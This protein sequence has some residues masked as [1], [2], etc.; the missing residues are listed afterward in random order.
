MAIPPLDPVVSS[1]IYAVGHDGEALY[2]RFK[3]RN[4]QP[5]SIYRYPSAGLEHH[6][7]MLTADSAGNYFAA[8]IRDAHQGE[9]VELI[10][11]TE[12]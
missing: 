1:N 6:R 3:D 12:T 4:K 10:V 9:I 8:E 11:S 7:A 2:V 5:G